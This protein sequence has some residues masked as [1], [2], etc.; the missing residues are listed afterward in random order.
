[1]LHGVKCMIARSIGRNIEECRDAYE[2]GVQQGKIL[3]MKYR[4]K[5]KAKD[6][7]KVHEP[8]KEA[9]ESNQ[10]AYDKATSP[11]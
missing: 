9:T 5:Q 11:A 6:T 1:M 4:A 7:N 3:A 8:T 2:E 10:Y